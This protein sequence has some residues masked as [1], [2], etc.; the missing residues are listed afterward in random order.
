MDLREDMLSIQL[1]QRFT[2]EQQTFSSSIWNA[3]RYA[4]GPTST[5]SQER[6]NQG[7]AGSA[8]AST[9]SSI[10]TI[11]RSCRNCWTNIRRWC[12]ASPI[13]SIPASH[14]TPRQA[15]CVSSS[16]KRWR[17]AASLRI[18]SKVP[19]KPSRIGETLKVTPDCARPQPGR[20][21]FLRPLPAL[22]IR[23]RTTGCGAK[24][25]SAK[26][27]MSVEDRQ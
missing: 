13:A 19:R 25:T 8:G 6:S 2:D 14:A 24:R 20:S 4:A 17:N 3:S 22:S 12:A 21:K 23:M 1:D 15:S 16:A 7:S 27:V 18:F 5:R 10:T 11:S 26:A 9:L